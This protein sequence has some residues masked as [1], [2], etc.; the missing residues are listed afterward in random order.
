MSRFTQVC[1][2]L[3]VLALA[4]LFMWPDRAPGPQAVEPAAAGADHAGPSPASRSVSRTIERSPSKVNARPTEPAA[5]DPRVARE[6]LRA[7]ILAE[8]ARAPVAAPPPQPTPANPS[9]AAAPAGE[10]KNRIGGH[11]ALLARLN[12]D[13][14]PLASECIEA[15]RERDPELNGMLTANFEILSDDELGSIVETVDFPEP[16]ETHDDELRTC[17]RETTLSMILPEAPS[18]QEQFMLTL[19]LD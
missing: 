12:S 1:L 16:D 2:G 11:E 14:M 17:I 4:I 13:F 18:G 5:Q 3:M 10:L 9:E 7:S 19:P 15:A 6:Q 8:R